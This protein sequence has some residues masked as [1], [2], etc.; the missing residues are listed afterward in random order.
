M[1]LGEAESTRTV[2]LAE[3]IHGVRPADLPPEVSRRAKLGVLDTVGAALFGSMAQELSALRKA[4]QVYGGSGTATVWGS[5]EHTSVQLA[6]L[7]N[8]TAAHATELDDFGGGGHPGAVIVPATLAVGESLHSTGVDIVVA[9]VVGYEVAER[10]AAAMGGYRVHTQR[11]WHSTGTCCVFGAAAAAG[12]LL[13]LSPQQGASA[14]GTAA[15]FAAGTW[16]FLHDGSPVK[17]LHAGKASEAGVVAA[18]LAAQGWRGPWFAF[19]PHWGGVLPTY[20]GPE[21]KPDEV[22]AG[23]G[24]EFRIMNLG[25]KPYE[26]ACC[27]GAHGPLETFLDLIRE[28]GLRERDISQV[29]VSTSPQHALELGRQEVANLLHAQ[30][31]VPYALAVGLLSGTAGAEQY[32]QKWLEDPTVKNWCNRITVIADERLPFGKHGAVR[33]LTQDGRWYERTVR[34]AKGGREHPLPEDEV[35]SKFC[36]LASYRLKTGA[37]AE[38]LEQILRLEK[39]GDVTELVSLL[40]VRD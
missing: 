31:S 19:E 27:R 40:A 8:G 32:S 14:L 39:L 24:Q 26:Y 33:V 38:I 28:H 35:K 9:V 1:A 12:R 3:W 18:Y 2:R 7:L 5:A 15:S 34:E 23:L 25:I 21:A 16:A 36:R 4:T 37:V 13:G 29:E 6:A 10:V 11:G 17:R 22:V 30:L 20:A